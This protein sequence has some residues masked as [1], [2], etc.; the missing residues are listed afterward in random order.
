MIGTISGDQTSALSCMPGWM[1][2]A[3]D[4][5]IDEC[6]ASNNGGCAQRCINTPGS[7]YCQ[8][9]SGYA[10]TNADAASCVDINE[11]AVANG[12]CEQTC[13]NSPG[14]YFCRCEGWKQLSAD[15]HSCACV[16]FTALLR[17]HW[18][19]SGLTGFASPDGSWV[20]PNLADPVAHPFPCAWS[21][22]IFDVC[23]IL[24]SSPSLQSL[25]VVACGCSCAYMTGLDYNAST[26]ALDAF[27]G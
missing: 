23:T 4:Q 12:G 3:C 21:N 24:L 1:G 11:C 18:A 7:Y 20:L 27:A 5:D 22:G 13:F 8:C 17:Q 15:G 25:P 26:A 10:A 2:V 19:A 14:S 9:F 6:Q 16:D